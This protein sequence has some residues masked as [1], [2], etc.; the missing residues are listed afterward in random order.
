M[1]PFA[2]LNQALATNGGSVVTPTTREEIEARN[3]LVRD[4]EAAA[5]E[6]AT[7]SAEEGRAAHSAL[8]LPDYY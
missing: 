7:A 1:R 4:P 8:A 5:K 6:M 2:E 3:A